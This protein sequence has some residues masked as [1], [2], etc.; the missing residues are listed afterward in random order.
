VI[1]MKT[2]LQQIIATMQM[3]ANIKFGWN[4]Q[5]PWYSGGVIHFWCQ[6][7]YGK[8]STT[9]EQGFYTNYHLSPFSMKLQRLINTTST[10]E[11]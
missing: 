7:I 5:Y 4:P 9:C 1:L 6:W 8:R 11:T 3:E 2:Q 10:T